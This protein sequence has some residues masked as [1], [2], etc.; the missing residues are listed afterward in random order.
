MILSV[1]N[2]IKDFI[3]IVLLIVDK[4]F[5]KKGIAI[6]EFHRVSINNSIEDVHSVYPHEFENQIKFLIDKGFKF[7]DLDEIINPDIFS[8]K[9]RIVLTFDDGHKDNLYYAYPILKKY[10]IKAT[11]FVV[12]DYVGK[13]GWLNEEGELLEEKIP[14]SQRWE[15][16]N[17]EDL[18]ELSDHLNIE[19]HCATHRHLDRLNDEELLY[20][21]SEPK[22]KIKEILGRDAN[23]FCYPYGEYNDKVMKNLQKY[24]YLGACSSEAGVNSV[25]DRNKFELKRNIVGSGITMLQYR[26][27]LN[28][29]FRIY[30]NILSLIYKIV[31]RNK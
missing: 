30:S 16:L 28:N 15:L 13:S 17:W 3:S 1:K 18:K 19:A 11:I 27:V 8:S 10:N 23:F 21:L 12:S 25:F 9:K 22:R 20:Q 24:G 31:N 29:G 7:V 14:G 5:Y 4:L 2:I 26:L 6:L